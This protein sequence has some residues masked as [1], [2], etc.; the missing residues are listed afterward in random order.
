MTPVDRWLKVLLTLVKPYLYENGGPIIMLQ[1]ENEYGVWKSCDVPYKNHLRDTFKSVVGNNTILFT[2][3]GAGD[4][5]LSSG[6]IQNVFITVDS[7]GEKEPKKMLE[8]LRRHQANGPFV[9]SEYYVGWFDYWENPHNII[10]IK[11][12]DKTLELMLELNASVV[13]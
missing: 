7:G 9:N 8:I 3:D 13:M 11:P 5:Y 10:P 2:T 1:V 6:S 4:G 12:G